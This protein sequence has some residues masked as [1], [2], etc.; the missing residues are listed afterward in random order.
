M[1]FTLAHASHQDEKLEDIGP[2]LPS[3]GYATACFMFSQKQLNTYPPIVAAALKTH[4][5]YSTGDYI[6]S[7][8]GCK[9]YSSQ[10]VCNQLFM[11][12]FFQVHDFGRLQTAPALQPW[13]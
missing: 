3:K 9:V 6:V 7:F 12:Y 8:S 13:L 2:G 5:A 11:N 4:E 10:E 1:G